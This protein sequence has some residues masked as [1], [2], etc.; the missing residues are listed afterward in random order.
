MPS[1]RVAQFLWFVVVIVVGFCF[2]VVFFLSF[3]LKVAGLSCC[4]Y[5]K[6][7]VDGTAWSL[8]L[9]LMSPC[10]LTEWKTRVFHFHAVGKTLTECNHHLLSIFYFLIVLVLIFPIFCSGY[11]SVWPGCFNCSRD[12]SHRSLNSGLGTAVVVYGSW[13]NWLLEL[14]AG[15]STKSLIS[16]LRI[17]SFVNAGCGV[18]WIARGGPK[19]E[20]CKEATRNTKEQNSIF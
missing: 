14:T 20:T 1:W 8:S 12:G 19:K 10:S 13:H 17:P 7:T 9:Q 6:Q 2:G 3:V 16:I 15:M 18:F 4:G 11:E 5:Q